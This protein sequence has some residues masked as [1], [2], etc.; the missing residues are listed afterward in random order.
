MSSSVQRRFCNLAET[1]QA[2]LTLVRSDLARQRVALSTALALDGFEIMGDPIELQQVLLN[3]LLNAAEAARE[4]PVERRRVMV[5]ARV[6][7]EGGESVALVS[8]EDTGVGFDEEQ[9]DRLFAP[10]YTTK[11]GGLGMGLSIIR[12]IIDRHGGRIWAEAN[13]EHGATFH[14]TLPRQTSTLVQG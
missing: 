2:A 5:R 3:L 11:P 13:P 10:F 14:F 4:L 9:I 8:V 7:Q 1:L 6:E 12:S